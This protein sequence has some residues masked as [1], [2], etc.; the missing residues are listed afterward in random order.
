MP[1]PP[2]N[3]K[4]ISFT[5]NLIA[6]SGNTPITCGI[7]PKKK[8]HTRINNIQQHITYNIRQQQQ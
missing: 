5:D 7:I 8:H 2:K 6:F 3:Y 1:L 4:S